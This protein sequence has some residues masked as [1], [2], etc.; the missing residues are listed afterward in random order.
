MS[1]DLDHRPLPKPSLFANNRARAIK[2]MVADGA[3]GAVLIFGLPELGRPLSDF[4]PHFR[5]ESCFYWL[6]GVNEPECAVYIDVATSHT[7]LFYPQLPEDL[8]IWTGPL[9]TLPE[10][11]EKYG[12]DEVLLLPKLTEF[13]NEK[14]PATLYSLEPTFRANL[15]SGVTIPVD[16]HI[17][18]V[19]IGE[20]RQIKSEEELT[21]IKY[22]CDVNCDAFQY[23]FKASHPGIWAQQFEGILQ[24]KYIDGYC[25]LNAFATIVCSGVHC[26]TLHYH[27]NDRKIQDG[28]MVLVDAGCEYYCY[29]ADN[30]RTFPVNG[31]FSADQRAVYQAVLDTQKAVIAAAKPGVLWPDMA[32]LS[33]KVM[34]E[35]LL[36]AGLFQN[37]TADEIVASGAMA[38]FYPHGLG[39]GMGL[40]CHEIA[41]WKH[42]HERPDEYH[43]KCLRMGRVLEPGIVVTV[44]PG[45]YFVPLLYEPA[46]NDPKIGKYI[47]KEVCERFRKNVGGVRIEDDILITKDGN[48]NLSHIPKEIDELEAII[49]AG[50]HK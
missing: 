6:T 33:A 1:I 32:K 42:G 47:N 39:H 15:L 28:E 26:A 3:K 9:A 19:A 2:R 24:H 35:G 21:L 41:G 50:Q 4:E 38:V 17:A 20:E 36:K 11:K 18:L 13:L 10:L 5:Q 7:T 27:Q 49:A 31:K 40:D 25:R 46:F 12:M 22:A 34:A 29:A 30:T 23:V 44:E 48:V 43:V 37:G 14:K 8:A 45:C 16:Y